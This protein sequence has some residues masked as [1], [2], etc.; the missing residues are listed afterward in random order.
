MH[1]DGVF[2]ERTRVT[3]LRPLRA[4]S[5]G[6]LMSVSISSGAIPGASVTIVAIVLSRSGRISTGSFIEQY[7]P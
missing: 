4:V 1:S 3:P 7:T 5:R 6:T 2:A